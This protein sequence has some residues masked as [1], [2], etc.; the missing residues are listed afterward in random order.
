MWWDCPIVLYYCPFIMSCHT[1][2]SF[3]LVLLS[4]PTV[5]SCLFVFLPW[6]IVL[7]YMSC[8]NVRPYCPIQLSNPTVLS[9]HLVLLCCPTVLED[10]CPSFLFFCSFMCPTEIYHCPTVPSLL[11]SYPT[12]PSYFPTLHL[13]NTVLS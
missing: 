8:P 12:S 3:C 7:R 5:M 13:F 9:F 11:L 4:P 6:S 10:F 2:P 1:V